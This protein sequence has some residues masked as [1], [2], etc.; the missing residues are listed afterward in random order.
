MG[1]EE[2]VNNV[3]YNSAIKEEIKWRKK[4]ANHLSVSLLDEM[5]YKINK[6]G[7]DYKYL[8]D[9]TNRE[10]RD[11]ELCAI[12]QEFIPRFID[13]S[14]VSELVGV[15]GIKGFYEGTETIIQQFNELTDMEKKQ[16]APTYD[17]ALE[18]I[19]D[20][21]YIG[22]YIKMLANPD[23]AVKLSLTMIM[24]GK[25]EVTEA[26]PLF[27]S[28]LNAT[29]LYLN[30]KTSDLVFTALAALSYYQDPDGT[31][32]KAIE[33]KL[34]SDDKDVV[35]AAKKALKRLKRNS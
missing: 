17:N 18:R 13:K 16:E 3:I 28:Y 10:N 11:F 35:S 12:V 2:F 9:L 14:I 25:W 1:N 26:K 29:L 6:L 31:I 22:E 27:F 34:Q 19:G 24:L 23:D 5:L 21:R 7:Y 8:V 30:D 4:K 20:R 15:I 32:K 33:E